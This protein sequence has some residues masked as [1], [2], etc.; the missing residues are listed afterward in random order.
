MIHAWKETTGKGA[1][2]RVRLGESALE[3]M[4]ELG[5]IQNATNDHANRDMT[6]R[7][8]NMSMNPIGETGFRFV[9]IDLLEPYQ[10]MELKAVRRF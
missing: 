7:I 5:G 1:K 10:Q 4:S 8:G 9:R 2:V 3:A 6:V